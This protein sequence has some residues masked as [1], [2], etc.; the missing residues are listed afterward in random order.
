MK[1]HA[2]RRPQLR[3][4]DATYI[5]A[6]CAGMRVLDRNAAM[7]NRLRLSFVI[8]ELAHRGLLPTSAELHVA[9]DRA[10]GGAGGPDIADDPEKRPWC[11]V[12]L[13]VAFR[14][15]STLSP[16]YAAQFVAQGVSTSREI[17]RFQ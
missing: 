14:G 7:Y 1:T 5:A 16:E 9:W 4:A 11:F 6:R 3:E 13:W 17:L 2:E 15:E 10:C 8:D 12:E